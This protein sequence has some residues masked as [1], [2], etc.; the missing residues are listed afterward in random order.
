VN[1]WLSRSAFQRLD[2]ATQAGQFGNAGRNIARGPSYTSVDV[3]FVR[4]FALST[5]TRLQFRAEAFNVLNHVNLGLPVADLNSPSFGRILSA[6]PP[7]LMQFALKL[8]F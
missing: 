4:T 1:A 8:S 6:G 7:R 3:S 2:L 5:Q